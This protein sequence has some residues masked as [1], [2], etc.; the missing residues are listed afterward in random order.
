MTAENRPSGGWLL[1]QRTRIAGLL[2]TLATTLFL[3]LLPEERTASVLWTGVGVCALILIV[4]TRP[5]ARRLPTIALNRGGKGDGFTLLFL[6]PA[7]MGRKRVKA[8]TVRVVAEI[9]SFLREQ[10]PPWS[11]SLAD[12]QQMSME[13]SQVTTEEE[14]A[15]IWNRYTL[16]QMEQSGREHQDLAARFG[17]SIRFLLDEYERRR[18]VAPSQAHKVEWMAG[19]VG[20]LGEAAAELEALGRRL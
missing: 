11:E 18:L 20:W 15:A 19:S 5:V 14:R 1:N 10:A 4:T 7:A 12:H 13:M 3:F 2:I 9:H 16:S 17:G 8:E 6:P